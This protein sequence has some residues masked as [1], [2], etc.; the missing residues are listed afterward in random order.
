VLFTSRDPAKEC[1]VANKSSL[2]TI[3]KK[4]KQ[5]VNK[6]KLGGVCEVV[7][8]SMEETKESDEG[9]IGL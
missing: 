6:P 4:S 7:P 3:N 9:V 2:A 1:L 8:A 5:G